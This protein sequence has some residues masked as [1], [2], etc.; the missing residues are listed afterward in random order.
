MAKATEVES[1]IQALLIEEAP[2]TPRRIVL[3]VGGGLLGTLQVLALALLPPVVA[4]GAL[5]GF[6]GVLLAALMRFGTAQIRR[7]LAYAD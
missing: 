7:L 5:V 2:I 1:A 3:V 4:L 6:N